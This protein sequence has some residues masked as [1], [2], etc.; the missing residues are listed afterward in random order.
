MSLVGLGAWQIGSK[1]WNGRDSK[2]IE[3]CKR[4]LL[5]GLE[6]GINLVDTAE[7]YGGGFSEKVVGETFRNV[8]EVV[9][10]TKVGGFRTSKYSILKAV[11][12]SKRRL[13]RD[14][15]DVILYHWPPPIYVPLCK[16]VRALEEAVDLG[17]ASY[18]GVSNFSSNLLLRALECLK[19]HDIV[20]N[21]VQ[22]SLAY[23]TVENKLKSLMEK[24][25]I[26]LMA[27]SPLAKG[28]L[29]GKTIPDNPARRGD[30]VFLEATRDSRLQEALEE[31][32]FKTRT[33]KARV[34]LAWLIRRGAIPIPGARKVRHVE[35]A[36][37]ASNLEL[38]SEDYERLNVV[39]EKY[40]EKW[41]LEYEVF[42][43][44]RFIP[45]FIQGL[46]LKTTEGI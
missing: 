24:E 41:G 38:A 1:S 40:V 26:S 2:T 9:I 21:Q 14:S 11:R 10:V 44:T 29:A 39:S 23:R 34:A 8:E 22:Y 19:K 13:G 17:L 6:L 30:R 16:V 3:E 27:W 4:A 15:I 37:L 12:A 35:E 7:V 33:S 31:V 20:V 36:A 28:A 43:Y 18:I 32:A 45:G 42:K 5:R 46:A 25:K